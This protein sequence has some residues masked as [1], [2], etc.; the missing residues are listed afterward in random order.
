MWTSCGRGESVNGGPCGRR[1][2]KGGRDGCIVHMHCTILR[3]KAILL[4]FLPCCCVCLCVCLCVHI[5]VSVCACVFVCMCA[6]VCVRLHVCACVCSSACV[7]MCV[8]ACMC[9][10]VCVC[11]RLG[12]WYTVHFL[13]SLFVGDFIVFAPLCVPKGSGWSGGVVWQYFVCDDLWL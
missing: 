2:V 6:H 10:H 13:L 8:F 9:A 7:R 1:G 5:C 12:T 4:F 11:I 3:Y